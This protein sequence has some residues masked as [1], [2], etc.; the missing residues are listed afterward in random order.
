M[1]TIAYDA[2]RDDYEIRDKKTG[3]CRGYIWQCSGRWAVRVDNDRAQYRDTKDEALA[4]A[5]ELAA[6]R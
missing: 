2:L 6:P 5:R 4:L 3:N 1:I